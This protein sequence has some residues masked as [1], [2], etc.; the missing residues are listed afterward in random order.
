LLHSH[1]GTIRE[2]DFDSVDRWI[3]DHQIEGPNFVYA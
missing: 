2:R 3:A 1:L